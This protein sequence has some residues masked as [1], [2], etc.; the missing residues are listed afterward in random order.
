MRGMLADLLHVSVEMAPAVEAALGERAQAFVV[1]P[2]EAFLRWVQ[3]ASPRLPGRV[4]FVDVTHEEPS[5]WDDPGD[6]QGLSGIHG[7]AD[8]YVDA[9]RE[10]AGLVRRLLGRT[11]IV[12]S[13]A[14]AI[15]L[16]GGIGRGE[17]PRLHL[18]NHA[19]FDA[20]VPQ[21]AVGDVRCG[22]RSARLDLPRDGDS[23][24]QVGVLRDLALVASTERAGVVHDHSAHLLRCQPAV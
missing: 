16:A 22:D 19:S 6:L 2:D 21:R 11:W 17:A 24:A 8:H 7:R 13:L 4:S 9:P 1:A 10:L 14:S 20:G 15:T 3:Q 5:A 23:P 18:A 12:E